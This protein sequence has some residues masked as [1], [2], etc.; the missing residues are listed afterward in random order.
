M[1]IATRAIFTG[2]I[3][4]A[5]ARIGYPPTDD[6][7]TR[8][9]TMVDY[10]EAYEGT[11]AAEPVMLVEDGVIRLW[12]RGGGWGADCSILYASCSLSDD[13]TVEAN[14]TKYASNPIYGDG[15]SDQADPAALPHVLK[16]GDTYWL[17]A[18]TNAFGLG[19]TEAM[20]FATSSDGLAWTTQVGSISRPSGT[21]MW[22]N[23]VVWKEG[24]GWYM[25]AEAGPT[26]WRI[27]LFTSSDGLA[28]SIGNG[29]DALSSL[30]VAADGAY[31]GPSILTSGVSQVPIL[32]DGLYHI[33][34]HAAPVSG[35]LPTN[36]YHATSSDRVTWTQTGAVLTRSGSGIE[37]DQVADPQILTINATAY[38]A[39]TGADNVEEWHVIGIATGIATP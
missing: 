20:V 1:G 4:G 11:V 31:G 18:I 13:C 5:T 25:L 2:A 9:G 6:A 10:T 7:W 37:V 28:W 32:D 26:P 14:W 35:S 16:V 22:G 12:Y 19:G 21:T 29:G 3:I 34:Y 36:I 39:Y 38:L 17:S 8:Q 33:W 27:Y 24:A 15:G 30:E 23:R